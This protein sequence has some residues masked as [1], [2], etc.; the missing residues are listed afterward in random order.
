MSLD[1]YSPIQL[2]EMSMLEVAYEV[3]LTKKQAIYFN[4]LVS[5]VAQILELSEEQV[6]KKI[7]QFY[8]DLNVDGRFICL[9][10]SQWGLRSWYPYEQI[11]EEVT[12]VAKPKKKKS[13]KKKD[14]DLD[15]DEFDDLDE[16]DLEFD[17][18]D[19]YE[20]DDDVID[21]EDDDEDEDDDDVDVVDEDDDVV[22]DFDLDEDSEDDDD[23]DIDEIDEE[24]EED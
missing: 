9:G 7:A 11:D 17:D 22:D 20:E 13:K 21:D 6:K 4:D 5:E 2:K 8:T 14:A 19:D 1:Q 18:L 10:E 3:F 12:V 16:E 23:L 15:I 24:E